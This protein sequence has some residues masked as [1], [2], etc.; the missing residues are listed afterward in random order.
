LF[1]HF[2]QDL[3]VYRDKSREL[4]QHFFPITSRMATVELA[5]TIEPARHASDRRWP[6]ES[7]WVADPSGDILACQGNP[8][9]YED[10]ALC[11]ITPGT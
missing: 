1:F 8:V 7:L 4:N 3:E 2:R 5:W 10:F 11:A 6:F 9:A